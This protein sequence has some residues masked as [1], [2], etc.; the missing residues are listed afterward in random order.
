MF[1]TFSQKNLKWQVIMAIMGGQKSI[2]SGKFKLEPIIT[3]Y[4]WFFVKVLWKYCGY[5]IFK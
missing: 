5:S 3:Y 1:I 4:L 2:L